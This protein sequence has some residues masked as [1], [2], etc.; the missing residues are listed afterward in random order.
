MWITE[1]L[2]RAQLEANIKLACYG[3][4]FIR[5][6]ICRSSDSLASVAFA[7]ADRSSG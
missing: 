2:A 7:D 3:L 1:N 6:L 5:H 4:L